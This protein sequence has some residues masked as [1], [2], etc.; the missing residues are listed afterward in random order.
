[1]SQ[2]DFED[3]HDDEL[4]DDDGGYVGQDVDEED[5]AE[6]FGD[7]EQADWITALRCDPVK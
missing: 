4:E 2:D 7:K 1:V 3:V 6:Y 5:V